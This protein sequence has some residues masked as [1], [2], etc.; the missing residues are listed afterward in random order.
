MILVMVFNLDLIN[1]K[2]NIINQLEQTIKTLSNKILD[3]EGQHKIL[4]SD[5]CKN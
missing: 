3:L 2:S 5:K 4:S 1:E